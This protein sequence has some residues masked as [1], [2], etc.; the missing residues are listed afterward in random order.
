MQKQERLKQEK[1][2]REQMDQEILRIS[3]AQN[4]LEIKKLID[5]HPARVYSPHFDEQSRKREQSGTE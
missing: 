1:L 5:G 4:P 3:E 2:K